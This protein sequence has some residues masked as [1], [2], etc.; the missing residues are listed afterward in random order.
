MAKEVT[1]ARPGLLYHTWLGGF[2]C[3]CICAGSWIASPFFS[4]ATVVAMARRTYGVSLL[5]AGVVGIDS[6]SVRRVLCGTTLAWEAVCAPRDVA[7]AGG[8]LSFTTYWFFFAAKAVAMIVCYFVC[9]PRSERFHEL[10]R[11][12]D[13]AKYYDGGV[14]LKGALED[15]KPEGSLFGFHPHGVLATGFSWNATWSKQFLELSGKD[16]MFMIDK[17]LREDCFFFKI[18]CDLHGGVASLTKRS[19]PKALAARKNVAFIPGGFEDATLAEYGKHATAI[20]RRT[21]FIKYA[22]QNGTRVHPCYTF[23]E[24]S[25]FYTFTGLKKLRL[26]ICAQGVPAV[27]FFGSPLMPLFPRMDVGLVTVV[28]KAIEFPRIEEP[29]KEEVF[30]WHKKYCDALV[31]LFEEHKR[32]AGVPSD[33]RLEIT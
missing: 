4:M 2:L 28:G 26:K 31:A 30:M 27:S 1:P 16:T 21:G 8:P 25:T 23:G 22:L 15:I 13:F 10:L 24:T 18:I 32:E 5:Y 17:T 11:G 20:K 19:F 9:F 3:H 12:L 33:A 29:S 7:A 6:P 14:K